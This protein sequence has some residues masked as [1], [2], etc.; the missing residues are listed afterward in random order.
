MLEDLGAGVIASDALGRIEI[1]SEEVKATLRKWWGDGILAPDGAVDRRKVASIIFRDQAQRHR[2]E[3]LLHPRVAV[4]RAD[5]LDEFESQPRVRIVVLDSPL[6]YEADL[7]LVCDAVIFVDTNRESRKLRSEKIRNWPAG[8]VELREKSQQ[9]L[10]IKRARAD[11]VCDNN[12][13]LAALRNQ[14][15]RI[16]SQIA[17][18]AGVS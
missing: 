8:E 6:L 9:P 18:E 2:L 11:Y 10:D 12:S 13:T 15:E 7:D 4:R 14:V 5:M 1:D 17:S 16:Y 3:A